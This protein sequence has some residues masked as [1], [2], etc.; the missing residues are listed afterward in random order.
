MKVD[1]ASE[2]CVDPQRFPANGHEWFDHESVSL[3][4]YMHST[5][6]QDQELVNEPPSLVDIDQL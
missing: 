2:R 1:G 4:I 6:E 3:F 5:S